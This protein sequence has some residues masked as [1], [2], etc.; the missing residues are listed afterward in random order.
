MVP[1]WGARFAAL[2]STS[3]LGLGFGSIA[4]AAGISTSGATVIAENPGVHGAA[5]DL[6][7]GLTASSGQAAPGSTCGR[8]GQG[9][10]CSGSLTLTV[11][12]RGGMTVTSFQVHR[13]AVGDTS[14]SDDGE[15]DCGS[16]EEGQKVAQPAASEALA[17]GA[18]RAQ[19]NGLGVLSAPGDTGLPTGTQVQVHVTLIDNGP[20][21]YGDVADVQVNQYVEGSTKP[22]I[23][24]SGIQMV[25][26]VQVFL[27]AAIPVPTTIAETPTTT[28]PEMPT[29]TMPETP[30][31]VATTTDAPLSPDRI[32]TVT[33][34]TTTTVPMPAFPGA[35][36]SYPNGSLVRFSGTYYV[37]AGGRAFQVPSAELGALRGIDRAVPVDAPAVAQPPTDAP[38]RPG[39][40]LTVYGTGNDRAIYV[41]GNDNR[42]YGFASPAQF[43][44]GGFDA[45]LVITVPGLT[46]L[47]VSKT[48]AAAAHIDALSTRS[49]GAL[50]VSGRTYYVFAGGMAFPVPDAAALS[51]LREVDPA[52]PIA[53]IPAPAIAPLA[54]GVILSVRNAGAYVTYHGRLFPFR[55]M[56]QLLAA[57]YGGTAAVAVAGWGDLPLVDQYAE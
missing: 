16:G 19:V 48:S 12:E 27:T 50:I 42:L 21:L 5:S 17:P 34:A 6:R 14:C 52:Q 24:E 35:E 32:D 15:D 45:A 13:I 36:D 11:P 53:G 3:L 1:T 2:L 28:T 39:T 4:F 46:G 57:G 51:A 23:Y 20:T 41:A 55:S 10:N 18:V 43:E 9:L 7:I 56:S 8:G 33:P 47:T 25:E 49:D 38:L 30:T 37:L 26:Q 54:D 29:T 31:T 22:L 40:L 44:E